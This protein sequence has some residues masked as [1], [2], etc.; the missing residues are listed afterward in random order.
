MTEYR[1]FIHS[2]AEAQ[3]LNKIAEKYPFDI[4]IHGQSG[5]ADAKSLLGLMLLTI[6]NDV[7]LVVNSDVDTEAFER[8][9]EEF[10]DLPHELAY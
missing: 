7:K 6:E 3:K 10:M 1:I 2:S 8:E 9:I 5:H 4:W